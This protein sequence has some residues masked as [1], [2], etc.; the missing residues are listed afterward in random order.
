MIEFIAEHHNVISVITSSIL[1]VI[2]LLYLNLFYVGIRR[3]RRPMIMVS[4]GAGKGPEARL[5]VS[6]MGAEPIYITA[7]IADAQCGDK[8]ITAYITQNDH[9]GSDSLESP[10][11]AT[12]EGPLGSGDY[13]DAG[14]FESMLTRIKL[15]AAEALDT[16]QIERL[17]LTVVAATGHSAAISAG[18]KMYHVIRRE[19]EIIFHPEKVSTE[20]MRNWLSRRRIRKRL[21]SELAAEL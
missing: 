21:E 13:L 19:D 9:I 2:W 10:D 20:Q 12:N 16:D 3:T 11:A 6:N 5:F 14:S 4:R 1:M 15:H 7:L 8:T 17:T 18:R